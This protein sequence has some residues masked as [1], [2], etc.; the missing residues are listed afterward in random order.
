[1][2]RGISSRPG[3]LGQRLIKIQ[4]LDLAIL[5][6]LEEG[7]KRASSSSEVHAG[8]GEVEI[9]KHL[10]CGMRAALKE[11]G[12]A[13]R[14]KMIILTGVESFSTPEV[15]RPDGLTDIP[16]LFSDIREEYD[17]HDPHAII[18]CKR[19]A[20]HDAGLSRLYVIKGIDRFKTGQSAGNHAVGFMAGYLLSGD[21]ESAVTGVNAYLTGK[22]RRSEHLGVCSLAGRSVGQEQS[23]SAPGAGRPDTA[24]PYVPRLA[25]GGVVRLR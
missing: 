2:I 6:T 23:T 21:A 20:G 12:A 8:S 17:E 25:A 3:V 11:T 14:K 1:M 15:P 10:R 4:E 13:W 19:V 5:W 24:A 9:T 7:W 16:V 18:E 22:G